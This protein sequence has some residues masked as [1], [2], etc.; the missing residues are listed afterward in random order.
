MYSFN[1]LNLCGLGESRVVF[2]IALTGRSN[3]AH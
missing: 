3:A 2:V 1:Q